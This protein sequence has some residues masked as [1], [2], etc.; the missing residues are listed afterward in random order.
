MASQGGQIGDVGIISNSNSTFQVI[1]TQKKLGD[2]FV[3]QGKLTKGKI[4]IKDPVN[5]SIDSK[6]RAN[7]RAYHSATHLMHEAL[8]RTLGKHVI[9][10]G[11][12]V[13]T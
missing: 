10:K 9:Q 11:S 4:K 13:G 6:R 2:I 12:F 8:R 5:L 3:H 1:D 7:I